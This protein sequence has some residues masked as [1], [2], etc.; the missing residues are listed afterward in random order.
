MTIIKFIVCAALGFVAY[1][2]LDQI[3]NLATTG[4]GIAC[5]YAIN[6]VKETLAGSGVS[7]MTIFAVAKTW[8]TINS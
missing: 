5:D 3:Q 8:A 2:H 6:H 1:N 7:A 4:L